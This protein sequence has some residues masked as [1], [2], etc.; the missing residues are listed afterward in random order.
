VIAKTGI[1]IYKVF[2]KWLPV[3]GAEVLVVEEL[4]KLP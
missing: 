1:D 3:L 4:K 2:L